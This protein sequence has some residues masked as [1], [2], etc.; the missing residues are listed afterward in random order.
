MLVSVPVFFLL[1]SLTASRIV[2]L[3]LKE[4][5]VS[6]AWGNRP[7][8][9]TQFLPSALQYRDGGTIQLRDRILGSSCL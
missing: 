3:V 7:Y 2:A 9:V 4:A 5:T 6:D 8:K 1:A